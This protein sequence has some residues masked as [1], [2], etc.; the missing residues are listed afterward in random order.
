[1]TNASSN[2]NALTTPTDGSVGHLNDHN[3]IKSALTIHEQ[4]IN[5]LQVSGGNT[6][7]TAITVKNQGTVI[8]T[9]ASSID[10]TGAGVSAG[11]NNNAVTVL[12]S[13]NN[14][15]NNVGLPN[16]AVWVYA[17]A[18][19]PGATPPYIWLDISSTPPNMYYV[20]GVADTLVY[21][22]DIGA[23]GGTTFGGLIF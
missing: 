21:T 3:N 11:N 9:S 5:S 13:G 16:G 8:T 1:M 10:F 22:K 15:G 18:F 12:V 4:A 14:S 20:V 19:D 7:A 17:A 2:I 23:F 6:G